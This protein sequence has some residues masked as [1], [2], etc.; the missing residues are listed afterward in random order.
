MSVPVGEREEN[1]FTLAIK[2][3][4]LAEYTI[5]ITAN[6]H[7]F[8]PEYRKQITDD[9]V[10]TANSIYLDIREANDTLVRVGTGFHM[11]D[12]RFRSDLQREALRKCK[13]LLY[14]I[15][16][17]HRIFHLSS[18]RVKYW[19]EMTI[20]VKNRIYGWIDADKKRYLPE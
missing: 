16:L 8:L 13:R 1:Q 19:C 6:E 5:R 14:L 12:Y 4:A 20:N 18:K 15:D 9:I 17:A 3:L 2:A 11:K 7:V 10:S